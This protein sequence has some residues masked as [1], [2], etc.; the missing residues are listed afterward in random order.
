MSACTKE[1]IKPVVSDAENVDTRVFDQDGPD[2][3]IVDLDDDDDEAD[4]DN[5]I[6]DPDDGD[7]QTEEDNDIIDPDDSDDEM[8][9]DDD[10]TT[11]ANVRIKDREE[12]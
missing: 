2:G 7:D 11:K 12:G 3:G 5:D 10:G 1:V 8:D 9:E 4:E 6:I